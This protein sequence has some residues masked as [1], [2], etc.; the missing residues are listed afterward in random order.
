[1]VLPSYMGETIGAER[2]TPGTTGKPGTVMGGRSMIDTAGGA[3][4]TANL[5]YLAMG[6]GKSMTMAAIDLNHLRGSGNLGPASTTENRPLLF[7]FTVLV[8][9]LAKTFIL[10]CNITVIP[11]IYSRSSDHDH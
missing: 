5:K 10:Q 6:I 1:M 9:T 8:V 4:K 11:A 3:G 2:K 7:L